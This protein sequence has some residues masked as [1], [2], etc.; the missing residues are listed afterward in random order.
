[1]PTSLDLLMGS[2]LISASYLAMPWLF[3]DGSEAQKFHHL[4]SQAGWN[5]CNLSIYLSRALFRQDDGF[6]PKIT[7]SF[8]YNVSHTKLTALG[9][10]KLS[11]RP[12]SSGQ[13]MAIDV[14]FQALLKSFPDATV[15]VGPTVWAMVLV[16]SSQC[17]CGRKLFTTLFLKA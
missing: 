6:E 17:H 10:I 14:A 3:L 9:E 5:R 2:P 13:A 1:M 7:E 16:S 11:F 8:V 12:G 15:A 4:I